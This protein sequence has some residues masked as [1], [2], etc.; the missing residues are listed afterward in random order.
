MEDKF[1]IYISD[2]KVDNIY[3]DIPQ[4]IWD[5]ISVELKV[6]LPILNAVIKKKD[7]D[8]A[9]KTARRKRLKKVTNY[10]KKKLPV[11]S[12]NDP[13]KYFEG[14]LPMR[15]GYPDKTKVVLFTGETD[16]TVLA[17]SGSPHHMLDARLESGVDPSCISTEAVNI[18]KAIAEAARIPV[19]SDIIKGNIPQVRQLIQGIN[20][21]QQ[22]YEFLAFRVHDQKSVSGGHN[23]LL[24]TPIYIALA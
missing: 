17:L 24:G 6:G 4:N 9:Q 13:K 18:F 8:E 15:R 23:L 11:G 1:Y 7:D 2:A 20:G 19:T 21:P 12:I 5:K 10:I 3:P 22:N 14:T 16:K